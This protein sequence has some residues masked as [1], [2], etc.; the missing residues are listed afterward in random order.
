MIPAAQIATHRRAVRDYLAERPSV[1]QCP[2]TIHRFMPRGTPGDEADVATACVV[3]TSLGQLTETNDPLGGAT[4]F[5]KITAQGLL[6]F[7]A[8]R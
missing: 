5:Y 7:E 8:G 4:K 2:E 6:D 1:S 3:L